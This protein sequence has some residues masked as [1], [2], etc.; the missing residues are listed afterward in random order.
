MSDNKLKVISYAL[1]DLHSRILKNKSDIN[2]GF[3]QAE[4][5]GI[6][7]QDLVKKYNSIPEY[8]LKEL[9]DT[10]EG[11]AVSYGL[12]KDDIQIGDTINIP[13]FL[14]DIT[15]DAESNTLSFIFETSDGEAKV[16]NTDITDLVDT[17]YFKVTYNELVN[18]RDESK[19]IAG[20]KYRITD[21][22]TITSQENTKSAGHQFDIIVTADSKN[23]L[24]ENAKAIQS[25][26]DSYFDNCNLS[27][28]ELKYTLDNDTSKYAWAGSIEY[29]YYDSSNCTITPELI[30]G[31]EFIE[32]VSFDATIFIDEDGNNLY[33]EGHKDM[34]KLIYEWGYFTVDGTTQLCLYI[35]YQD[36][37]EEEG[38]DYNDKYLYRGIITVDGEE[39][40]YWQKCEVDSTT[41][42]QLHAMTGRIVS[43][44]EN[45]E[46]GYNIN[47]KG[48]IYRMIDER[49]NDVPYD[50]K[51]I[52]M[53]DANNTEDATYY[54]TFSTV[55]DNGDII[56]N[57]KA[58]E[59]IINPWQTS[60]I[61][62]I[63]NI[64]FCG[65]TIGANHIGIQCYNNT[66]WG[67]ANANW[68]GAL[69]YNNQITGSMSH[70]N[71]QG[72]FQ[73]NKVY[74]T[75]QGNLIGAECKNNVFNNMTGNYIISICNNNTSSADFKFNTIGV[76]FT[77]NTF[78][79]IVQC[80]LGSAFQY[81][82]IGSLG[83]SYIGNAVSY[84]TLGEGCSILYIGNYC[85]HNTFG[86]KIYNCTLG[87]NVK[88][89]SIRKSAALDAEL[90]D[91]CEYITFEDGVRLT[92]YSDL[93]SDANNIFTSVTVKKGINDQ[94]AF[95]K[96]DTLN[97][98]FLTTVAKNSSGEIKVYCE[99]DLIA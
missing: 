87:N 32:P 90:Q 81:N 20:A 58:R 6:T 23:T 59:N 12:F 80:F 1:N 94:N 39:Y 63:N 89:C 29:L 83:N 52:M 67:S 34:E 18:L 69:C 42:V 3:E 71:I 37:Y 27:A 62:K 77:N 15:Y 2:K 30:N 16:I 85:H 26:N 17:F 75:L 98:E 19:L 7:I 93:V 92:L 8:S 36:I 79:S 74:N 35:S 84:N 73:N 41:Q 9:T 24:N 64:I 88:Y 28:W 46:V 38:V 68:F 48:V 40:D 86:N 57:L 76:G 53:R 22:M 44:P 50:F 11:S 60:G 82:N 43:N 72:S 45:F 5:M 78:G 47:P 65:S 96:I 4:L 95:V 55:N 61:N 13:Q 33:P 49:F 10:T 21:Y 91:Y 97:N 70:N 54:Y 56:E 66:F 51:N 31:N 25:E 99:A 14:K